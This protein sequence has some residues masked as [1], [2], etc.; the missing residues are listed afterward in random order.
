VP[1]FLCRQT[2]LLL[3][4]AATGKAVAVKKGQFMAPWDMKNVVGK[5][6]EGGCRDI[7]LTERGVTFGYG[8]LVV[9]FRSLPAMRA[10]GGRVCCVATHAVQR[11]G[12]LGDRSGGDRTEV[13]APRARGA[14]GID[15][16]FTEVHE[17][18]TTRRRTARTCCSSTPW[19]T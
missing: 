9:D 10:L 3:A 13:P 12:G 1:A 4:A 17:D 5:L 18:S 11:P 16:L 14:V 7:L 15:A 19:A 8:A 6:R 2:D